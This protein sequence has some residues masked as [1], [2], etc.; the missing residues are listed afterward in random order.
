VR[1]EAVARRLGIAAEHPTERWQ[2]LY[3]ALTSPQWVD[4]AH[5]A[6]LAGRSSEEIT[7]SNMLTEFRYGRMVW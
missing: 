6:R 5:E 7:D 4:V 1:L 2:H 3:D